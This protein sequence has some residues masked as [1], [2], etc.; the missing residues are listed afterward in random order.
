M[1]CASICFR[2]VFSV[3]NVFGTV[4]K[5]PFTFHLND[6]ASFIKRTVAQNKRKSFSGKG[7][8]MKLQDLI[9]NFHRNKQMCCQSMNAA[10]QPDGHGSQ[11][12]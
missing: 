4:L 6:P 11:Q 9:F 5:Q 1:E 2:L 12:A 8:R 3:D 10:Y 7:A